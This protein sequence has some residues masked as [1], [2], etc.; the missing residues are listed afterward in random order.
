MRQGKAYHRHKT[1]KVRALPRGVV[2]GVSTHCRCYWSLV[3]GTSVHDVRGRVPLS[4]TPH[5]LEVLGRV[6]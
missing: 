3:L 2:K 6:A 4:H 5:E 1:Q